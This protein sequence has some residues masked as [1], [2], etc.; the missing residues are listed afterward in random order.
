MTKFTDWA[1]QTRD[2]Y[3]LLSYPLFGLVIVIGVPLGLIGRA[4]SKL[5][6]LG[7]ALEAWVGFDD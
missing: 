1:L 2:N 4:L 5:G 3:P 7:E 6:K